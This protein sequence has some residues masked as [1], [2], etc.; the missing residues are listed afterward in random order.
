MGSAFM[1]GS[2]TYVGGK[3]DNNMIAI[4]AQLSYKI[5]VANLPGNSPI[6][7]D[8]SDKPRT[9][10]PIEV[11]DQVTDM[12]INKDLSEWGHILDNIDVE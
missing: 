3:F 4:I 9:F 5:S 12:M 6:L 11:S 10:T 2:H 7:R 1:H 8:I